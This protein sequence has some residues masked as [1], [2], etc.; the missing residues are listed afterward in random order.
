MQG[1][2]RKLAMAIHFEDEE[3]GLSALSVISCGSKE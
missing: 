3:I 2:E 1:E